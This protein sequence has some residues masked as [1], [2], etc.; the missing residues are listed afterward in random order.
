MAIEKAIVMHEGD[1][2]PGF[3]SVDVLYYLL[4]PQLDKL[5]EPAMELLQDIY[6]Q[7]ETL[8]HNIIDKIFQRFPSLIP[9]LM[10]VVVGVL[11]EE[12]DHARTIVEA[13]IDAEQNYLFTNDHNYKENRTDIVPQN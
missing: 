3:P 7:L 5:R 6:S 1:S 10:D 13:I 9:E 11:S 4:Q 8:A 12:R 2:I